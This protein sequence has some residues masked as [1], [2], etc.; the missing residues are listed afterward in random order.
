MTIEDLISSAMG[1]GAVMAI[2]GALILFLIKRMLSKND[3]DN[4]QR[5]ETLKDL[6][7]TIGDF[8][9]AIAV[10]STKVE[11]LGKAIDKIHSNGCSWGRRNGK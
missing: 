9:T 7:N 11:G 4:A 1:G 8:K 10:L 2:I 5:D 3:K 6:S